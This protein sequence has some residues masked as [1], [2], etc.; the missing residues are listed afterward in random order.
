LEQLLA[1]F[2]LELPWT[3]RMK[4]AHDIAS[5][6]TYLHSRG[7]MHRDLTS[8]VIIQWTTMLR[9]SMYVADVWS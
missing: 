7:I 9:Q 6:M 2:D 3:V 1:N 5:G 4:I 8:K